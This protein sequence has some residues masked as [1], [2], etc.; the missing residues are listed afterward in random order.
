MPNYARDLRKQYDSKKI[1]KEKFIREVLHHAEANAKEEHI[2][3]RATTAWIEL[4]T[5]GFWVKGRDIFSKACFR[6][7]KNTA[8][9]GLWPWNEE[10]ANIMER[11]GSGK[12]QEY[13]VK[14]EFYDALKKVNSSPY[15]RGGI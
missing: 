3:K 13:K 5:K 4:G 9:H 8:N 11:K 1:S 6:D 10:N 12:D 14:E 7:Y 15:P 2:V